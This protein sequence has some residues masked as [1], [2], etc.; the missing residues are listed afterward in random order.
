MSRSEPDPI[1][2]AA[3]LRPG[4]H[5]VDTTFGLGRDALVASAAVGPTG[6]VI[7]TESSLPLFLLGTHGLEDGPLSAAELETLFGLKACPIDLKRTEAKAFLASAADDSADVVLVD[8]MFGEPKTSDKGFQ[9]L[10]SLADLTP[11]DEEWITEAKRVARRWVIVK[12]G[13]SQPWFSD[14]G[15][16][17]VRGHSNANWWRVSGS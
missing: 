12:C 16:E 6:S 7:A 2:R 17:P 3:E 4:D 11:L 9:I 13:P 15:L 5:V 14:V 10:R 8:P 1:V